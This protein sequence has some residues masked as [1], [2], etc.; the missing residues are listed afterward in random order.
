MQNKVQKTNDI[1]DAITIKSCSKLWEDNE[2][3]KIEFPPVK[4]R[5]LI[6]NEYKK[7]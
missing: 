4:I 3:C 5:V 6:E 7:T 2:Y 1:R